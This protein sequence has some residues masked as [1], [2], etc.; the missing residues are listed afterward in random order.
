MNILFAHYPGDVWAVALVITAVLLVIGAYSVITWRRPLSASLLAVMQMAAAVALLALLWDPSRQEPT[1]TSRRREVLVFFDTSESMSLNDTPDKTSRLDAAIAGFRTLT[2]AAGPDVDFTLYGFAE[3]CYAA[4]QEDAFRRWGSRTNLDAVFA[5][6]ARRSHAAGALVFTDGQ[7]PYGSAAGPVGGE[8]AVPLVLAGVGATDPGVDASIRSIQAPAR[9]AVDH[10]YSVT[11]EAAVRGAAA[12]NASLEILSD[13]VPIHREDVALPGQDTPHSV[14]ITMPAGE[15][16]TR[17][18]TARVHLA[19]D[20][21][22]GN[23][24]RHAQVQVVSEPPLRV[25]LYTQVASF[26]IG[27]MRQVLAR[28]KRVRLDLGFDVL[29]DATQAMGGATRAGFVRDEAKERAPRA[30]LMAGHVPLPDT[31]EGFNEYD[32]IVLG[33]LAQDTL[34]PDQLALLYDFVVR[35]G[36]GLILLPGPDP[37]AWPD[38]PSAD[39]QALLPVEPGAARGTANGQDLLPRL[40][41][42]GRQQGSLDEAVLREL[43]PATQAF[44]TDVLPKPAA[45]VWIEAAGQP[46]VVVHRVGRG[47]VALL[48]IRHLYRWYRADLE[49]GVLRALVSEMLSY[50]GTRSGTDAQVELLAARD[51]A[52]PRAVRFD[53]YVYDRQFEHVPDATVLLDVEGTVYRMDAGG[54]GRYSLRLD[55]VR[56]ESI[57]ASASAEREGELVGAATLAAHLPAVHREMDA[58]ALNRDFLVALAQRTGGLY[59]DAAELDTK[60]LERFAA[61][62]V[63]DESRTLRSAWRRWPVF[64]VLCG[65]LTALWLVRRS[66]GYA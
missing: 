29:K 37:W 48:N 20:V 19:D 57:V 64:L 58:V 14:T 7:T 30:G 56:G 15:A 63:A 17:L 39:F 33:P 51:A 31:A 46:L 26:D 25:L 60:V 6:L 11:V 44:H 45:S 52:D 5:T 22:P 28:D 54:N 10:T 16:G 12:A 53:A 59:R 8:G 42:E 9:V 13:G 24:E 27:K 43:A 35:R 18:V 49:G 66:M 3:D 2:E 61:R 38:M 41:L 36:A 34:K 32:L 4:R 65:W 47:R 40:T 62:P 1:E 50:A 23:D 55:D 21:N